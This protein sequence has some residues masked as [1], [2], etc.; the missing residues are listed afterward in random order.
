MEQDKRMT[1]RKLL[2]GVLLLG[3]VAS[4][5]ANAELPAERIIDLYRKASGGKALK[6]IKATVTTGRIRRGEAGSGRFTYQAVLPDR[7]RMD[8]EAGDLQ[9]TECYNGKSAW[10]KDAGG[11]RTLHGD[12]AKTARL[13]ALIANARMDG[14][15]RNRIMARAGGRTTLDGHA[16]NVLELSMNE[17]QVRFFFDAANHLL[18]KRERTTTE[19]P[20][21]VFYGDYRK[22]DG[23]MEPHALRI[24]IGKQEWA[25]AVDR[26][27]HNRPTDEAIFRYPQIAPASP[28]PDVKTLMTAIVANQQKIE[29]LRE[30]YTFREL[31][32]ERKLDGAGRVKDT[33][34]KL[35]DVTPMAGSTVRRLVTTNG[36]ELSAS[37]REKEDRRVQKEVEEKLRQQE[38]R[39]KNQAQAAQR[40]ADDND[41]EDERVTILN[42]LRIS[43]ATSLRRENFRGHDVLAFDFEPRKGFQPQN[44]SEKIVS[45]LAGTIW[46]DEQA[47]QIVRLEARLID[48]YKIAGGML[49]SI[50]P[51]TAFVFEQE[52]VN[53]EVW[54]PSFAEVNLSARLFLLAKFN[55]FITTRYS[56]YRKYQVESD[57]RLNPP[58]P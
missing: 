8:L 43:E 31:E 15:G 19:G 9:F 57:Y 20:E 28:L 39:K 53:N 36:K 56:D 33:E 37:E 50:S 45:K 54:L 2:M 24:K 4:V 55:R 23:V 14:L 26:I 38:K 58:N 34:T 12:D 6:R 46:I 51:S 21:E 29:E 5:S 40:N 32:I 17:A 35:Y 27:E 7:L 49:A 30:R 42:F 22:V 1:M 3:A 18:V 25:I 48:S 44:R 10:R 47:N 13:L 41:E 52:K 11:L 16:V